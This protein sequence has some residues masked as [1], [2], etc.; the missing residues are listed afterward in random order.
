[1]LKL[2][3]SSGKNLV[4]DKSHVKEIIHSNHMVDVYLLIQA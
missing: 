3:E 1:M 2:T 4:I